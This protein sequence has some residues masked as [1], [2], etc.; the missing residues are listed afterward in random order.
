MAHATRTWLFALLLCGLLL[1]GVS[2]QTPAGA[3]PVTA[4]QYTE[5]GH[6]YA[7][8]RVYDKAVDAYRQAI[9]VN[10]NLAAAYQGLGSV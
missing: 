8:A 1:P 3:P 10:P 5:E 7:L 9:K 4:E 2:A 6:K